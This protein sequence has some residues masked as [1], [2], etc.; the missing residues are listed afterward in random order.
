MG[1]QGQSIFWHCNCSYVGLNERKLYCMIQHPLAHAGKE[2]GEGKV[3]IN[4]LDDSRF[5]KGNLPV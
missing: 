3:S 5:L 2:L 1:W 4:F